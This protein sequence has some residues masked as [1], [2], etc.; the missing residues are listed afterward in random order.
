MTEA[1]LMRAGL[2]LAFYLPAMKNAAWVL[3]RKVC[4]RRG[5]PRL[6]HHE[7]IPVDLRARPPHIFYTAVA[8]LESEATRG[9]PGTGCAP[10]SAHH[11]RTSVGHF[12]Y[13]D[14]QARL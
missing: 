11:G 10:G 3:N 12:L 7:S 2:G 5:L 6:E 1:M 13:W 9:P 4:R 14:T 8:V